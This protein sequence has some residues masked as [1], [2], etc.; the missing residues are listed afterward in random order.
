MIILYYCESGAHVEVHGPDQ[1]CGLPS[2][3]IATL[4]AGVS[5][6]PKLVIY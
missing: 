2:P 4:L 3:E 5:P 6:K 1:E